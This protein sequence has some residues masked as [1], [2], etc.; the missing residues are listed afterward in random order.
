MKNIKN[1]L[2]AILVGI[3]AFTTIALTRDNTNDIKCEAYVEVYHLDTDMIEQLNLANWD[4]D[5]PI[6]Y[7]YGVFDRLFD[8]PNIKV[9]CK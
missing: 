6:E 2:I 8:E 7:D 4:I 3:T 1:W 9:S 5:T